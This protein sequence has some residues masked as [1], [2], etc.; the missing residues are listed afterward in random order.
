MTD[1]SSN[2]TFIDPR[3]VTSCADEFRSEIED[4]QEQ[5]DAV[6]E[7]L[8]DAKV[9]LEDELQDEDPETDDIEASI[10]A[11]EAQK[12]E[13]EDELAELEDDAQKIFEL[14]SDCSDYARGE[15]LINEDYWVTYAQQLAE[16]VDGI[17][18]SNWPFTC[19]DWEQA[20]DVLAMDY[21][22]ITFECQDFYVRS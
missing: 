2:D 15:S 8:T 6:E 5:I 4:K 17:D 22:T 13:F 1:I 3:D 11:F 19:I 21:T 12:S 20:A 10:A 18:V 14:E 7:Q 9:E 16:D